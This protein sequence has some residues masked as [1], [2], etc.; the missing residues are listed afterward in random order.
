MGSEVVDANSGSSRVLWIS[1][2]TWVV[3]RAGRDVS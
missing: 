2:S 1:S 3:R